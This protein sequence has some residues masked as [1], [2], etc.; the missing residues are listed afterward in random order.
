M[1]KHISIFIIAVL[2]LSLFSGLGTVALAAGEVD[3]SMDPGTVEAIE[4]ET[5][6]LSATVYNDFGEALSD[7]QVK[8]GTT[9]TFGG[10]APL[11]IGDSGE[12]P[13]SFTATSEMIGTYLTFS[14]EY[15][16]AS[17]PSWT[18]GNL[19]TVRVDKKELTVQ[20]DATASV[21]QDLVDVG[22]K[23]KFT[24]KLENNGEATLQNIVVKA[25][26][27]NSGGALNN[28][29]ITLT[30]GQDAT[31][32]YDH[33]VTGA[34]TVTPTISYSVDGVAQTP[35]AL[36]DIAITIV[37]RYVEAVLTV[38][39]KTPDVDEE[40]TFTLT[41]KND[42]TVPYTNLAVTYNGVDIG[43]PTTKLNPGD[44]KS[45]VY[46]MSFQKTTEVKFLISLVDHEN[47]TKSVWSN[48]VDI[49]L[50]VD[51]DVLRE[52]VDLTITADVEN[53][54]SAGTVNF[55]GKI[56]NASE[57]LLSNVEVNETVLENVFGP[58]S[59][60]SKDEE[61]FSFQANINE[62]TTYSFVL[63][64]EDKD[65]V[66]YTI[67]AEPITVTITAADEETDFDNA[68]DVELTPEEGSGSNSTKL[69]IILGVV[70]FVLII[71]VG[72]TL[73][74]LWKKGKRPNKMSS[75][76]LVGRNKK[77]PAAKKTGMK[78][79]SSS[80]KSYKDRN[81]F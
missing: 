28:E 74:V 5:I 72:V 13:V 15:K 68:A 58:V 67:E 62:T 53:L 69:L 36:S 64:F 11:A 45:E 10:G 47:A 55:K 65:G 51:Q 81:N 23:V 31:V 4:G 59:M 37:S 80:S 76:K 33:T 77:A 26:G 24:F 30:A 35:K 25:T 50:P 3:L 21:S 48:P 8:L 16:T 66:T 49:E 71:G 39:N 12:I 79:K 18:A 70:L 43:F 17:N 75:S 9:T 22:D 6:N 61:E 41:I 46:T 34:I 73:L 19:A 56:Y 40:V 7:Y 14:V 42:G 27:L 1:K 38:D 54:P 2:V 44:E 29:P 52:S 32:T 20:L 78:K 57:Y 63:T 60:A